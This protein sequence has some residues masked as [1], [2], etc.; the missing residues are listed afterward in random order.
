MNQLRKLAGANEGKCEM[1]NLL[2]KFQPLLK[3]F[4]KKERNLLKREDL[5]SILSIALLEAA[6]RYE[7]PEEKFPGYAKTFLLNTLRNYQRKEARYRQSEVSLDQIFKEDTYEMDHHLD[8]KEK[9]KTVKEVLNQLTTEE[10]N[11]LIESAT[12]NG[13]FKMLAQKH[14]IPPKTLYS[15]Y[16]RLLQKTRNLRKGSVNCL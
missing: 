2:K 5:H 11:L 12:K 6:L 13:S 14:H 1:V 8:M 7:G 10:R 3:H 15:R 9:I 16:H 4:E